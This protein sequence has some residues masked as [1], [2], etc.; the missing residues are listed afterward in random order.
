[1]SYL[2]RHQKRPDFQVIDTAGQ[3]IASLRF[4][5]WPA[6]DAYG[7]VGHSAIA[8]STKGFWKRSTSIQ[9]EGGSKGTIDMTFDREL[10][11]DLELDGS[12]QR[13][14]LVHRGFWR[15]LDMQITAHDVPLLDISIRPRWFTWPNY[16]VRP[17][18]NRW[19][20]EHLALLLAV[21][22]Y[23]VTIERL[24]RVKATLT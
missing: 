14:L 7:T 6:Y 12:T 21:A 8:L 1:M 17:T 22:G 3:V 2:I 20:E 5:G 23:M 18:A 15:G 13:V 4:E 11:A 9:F 10:S 24:L 19:P 16:H